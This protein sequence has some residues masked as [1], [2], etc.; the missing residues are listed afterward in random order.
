MRGQ[1]DRWG[2]VMGRYL[3]RADGLRAEPVKLTAGSPPWQFARM[4]EIVNL[5][6]LRGVD[7]GG[8]ETA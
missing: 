1:R 3:V 6:D 8:E 4:R 2:A 7:A 5:A